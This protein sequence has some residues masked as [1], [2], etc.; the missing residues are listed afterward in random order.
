MSHST[1]SRRNFIGTAAIGTATG[2]LPA[3]AIA[4]PQPDER[5]RAKITGMEPIVIAVNYADRETTWE[6]VRLETDAGVTG[7]G[8]P[9]HSGG[10][11]AKI[12][13][14]KDIFPLLEGLS[15]F[16]IEL[17]RRRFL[18]QGPHEDG[19]LTTAFCGLE[20]AMWDLA[21]KLAGRSIA[22]MLGGRL[23]DRLRVYANINR[24]TREENRS[25]EG[26]AKNAKKACEWGFTA[27]KMAPFDDMAFLQRGEQALRKTAEPGVARIK[28]VRDAIGDDVDLLIDVHSR[29][30]VPFGI[31]MTK[32]LEPYNL[33]WLEEITASYLAEDCA[34]ITAASTIRTA[35]GEHLW[36]L[37]PFGA[38]LRHGSYDV[39]MPDVKHCGG[40]LTMKKI[41]AIA[42]A[43]GSTCSPHNP[44]GPVATAASTQCCATMPNFLI[45]EYA[46]GEVPWRADLITPRESFI[47][48]HIPVSQLPGLGI[49]L[50]DRTVEAHRIRV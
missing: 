10:Y 12:R 50:N 27:I 23:H 47:E 14:L 34:K 9:S 2:L 28:A 11:R 21:G 32:R 29:F 5:P 46:W 49:E 37:E 24:T 22:E 31:E 42:E 1:L 30:G 3:T 25:P 40:I 13:A 18:A 41:S 36:E 38:F 44:T 16:D 4:M 48:G 19:A 43:N 35:G 39:F 7:I 17:F 15:P 45:L 8:E 6:F 20:H 33:F 26:F